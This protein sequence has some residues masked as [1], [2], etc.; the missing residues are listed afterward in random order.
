VIP[1]RDA[2][3]VAGATL[4]LTRLVVSDDLGQ[5]WVKDPLNDLAHKHTRIVGQV[6][7]AEALFEGKIELSEGQEVL[8]KW[9]RYLDGLDCPWCF[10]YWAGV[11]VLGSYH[12]SGLHPRARKLWRFGAATLSLSAVVGHISARID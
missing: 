11:A 6:A 8:P 7:S 4:R 1:A 5:W 10:G 2:A 3:L 9:A 12:L